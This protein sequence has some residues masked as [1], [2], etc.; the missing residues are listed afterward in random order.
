MV[1]GVML[2]AGIPTHPWVFPV[3]IGF[4]LMFGICW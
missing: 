1:L 4:A 3:F 2:T